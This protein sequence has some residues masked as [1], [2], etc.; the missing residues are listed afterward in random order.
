MLLRNECLTVEI[1]ALGGELRSIRTPDGTEYLWQGHPDFW[2]SRAINLFPF[3]GRLWG[4][5]YKFRGRTYA[6]GNHGFVRHTV[7]DEVPESETAGRMVM[8][9]NADTRDV[10]PFRF[11]YEIGYLL[12]GPSLHITFRVVNQD[13]KPMYFG[14]GGHPGFNVPLEPGKVFT[15]YQVRF[16]EAQA[17]ERVLFGPTCFLTGEKVPYDLGE[18]KAIGLQHRLFDHDVILLERSGSTAIIEPRDGQGKAVELRYPDCRYLGVWHSVKTDAPF[19]CLEP[20]AALPGR[21]NL[22]EDFETDPNIL[23]LEVGETYENR[24]TVTVR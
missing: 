14:L 4:G 13:K 10:Y 7:M 6:L 11:R 5:T 24:L 19:V 12:E 2:K 18:E 1:D 20:W 16:P 22:T 9:D 23:R 17:P 15:D 3:V 21:D 8:E